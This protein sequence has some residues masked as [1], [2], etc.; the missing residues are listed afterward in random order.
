GEGPGRLL[1]RL[2]QGLRRGRDGLPRQRAPPQPRHA[3]PR[4][5][6]VAP[7]QGDRE[8]RP[9]ARSRRRH[10]DDVRRRGGARAADLA[11]VLPPPPDG[12]AR[13]RPRP[14]AMPNLAAAVEAVRAH[15]DARPALA[16]VLGSGLGGL[17]DAAEDPVVVPTEV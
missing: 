6:E 12:L 17:A 10:L 2:P 9:L 13:R 16:L 11:A 3:A 7:Q 15:A 14:T 8:G 1:R 5:V 4:P